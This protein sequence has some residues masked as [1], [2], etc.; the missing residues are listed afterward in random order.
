MVTRPVLAQLV[1]ATFLAFG[2]GVWLGLAGFLVCAGL[3]A[4]IGGTVAEMTGPPRH[5]DITE[6]EGSEREWAS[7]D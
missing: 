4:I 6:D 5:T 7:A 3:C 2:F 1:G